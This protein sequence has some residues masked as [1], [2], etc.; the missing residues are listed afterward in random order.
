MPVR[1]KPSD[2]LLPRLSCIESH[3]SQVGKHLKT[4]KE[5]NR[6]RDF[7]VSSEI[8]LKPETSAGMI[9]EASL[10]LKNHVDGI[11]VTDNQFGQLH[12]STLA[13]AA[14]LISNGVDP[15]V[16]LACRNRNRIALLSE[17]L[18]AA[19]LGV[20]SL[21][22]IRGNR[23][24]DGFNPRPKAVLDLDA[25][26]LIATASKLK[27]DDRLYSLPDFFIGGLVT[28]HM[29]KPGWNPQKLTKKVDA[30]A[31]FVQSHVCMDI[32]LLQ[33][34]MKHLVATGLLRRIS[35]FISLA[36]PG[37]AEDARWL[38]DNR[39]NIRFPANLIR[40]I[41][42]AADPEQESVRIC[43]E[44]MQQLAEVP[45]VGGAHLVATRNLATIPA[46]IEASGLRKDANGS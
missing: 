15:I 27:L 35:V 1:N 9:R 31:Q 19:A 29:P 24:P 28:P 34:Y 41:E 7:S 17:L 44:H 39:P 42:Q 43:A 46:A 6:I 4:F 12:M 36:I 14:L 21:I 10:L 3:P 13:A 45:G 32:P 11:L 33:N 16:Q 23:V 20:T 26:E 37:S 30:G 22:L 2:R 25:T 38:R 40:R 8:F 5:A 18:G